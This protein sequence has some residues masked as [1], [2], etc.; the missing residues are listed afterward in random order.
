MS[1]TTRKGCHEIIK[2]TINYRPILTQ[3]NKPN[4]TGYVYQI[5]IY[6][7]KEESGASCGLGSRVVKHLTEPLIGTG[8]HVTFDNFFSTVDLMEELLE[9]KIYAT[10]TV[11]PNRRDLPLVAK[12][13]SKLDKGQSIWYT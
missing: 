12:Q 7:G 1:M 4:K 8:T 5:D 10:C 3:M 6:T 11:G 13:S 2:P 9:K